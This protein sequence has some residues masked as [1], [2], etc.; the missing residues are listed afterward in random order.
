VENWCAVDGAYGHSLVG[1]KERAKED[2]WGFW[3]DCVSVAAHATMTFMATWHGELI[4][5]D[6]YTLLTLSAEM[7]A[8]KRKWKR[9]INAGL[10]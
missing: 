5:F 9:E 2:E 7:I 6:G 1:L 3:A 10:A 8:E 4:L